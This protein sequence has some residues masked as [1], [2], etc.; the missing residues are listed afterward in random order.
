MNALSALSGQTGAFVV[1][2]DHF[3]KV[4]DAGTRG[5]SA[6]EGAVDTVLGALGNRDISGAITDTRLVLRKQRD[7]IS[8]FELPYT[9]EVIETG[10]DEDDDPITA[11]ILKWN[12]ARQPTSSENK[13]PRGLRLLRRILMVALAAAGQELNSDKNTIVRAVHSDVVRMEFYRQYPGEGTE[14]QRKEARRKAFNRTMK[15][16]QARNLIGCCEADGVQWAW[17]AEP[18][19]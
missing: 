1:G 9:A 3:G 18:E 5:S 14:E 19:E 8:G 16:A 6:K 4:A 13:W 12:E 7:G 15:D 17:L 10:R 11:V 2:V